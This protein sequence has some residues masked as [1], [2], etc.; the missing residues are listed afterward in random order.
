MRGG[1]ETLAE[2]VVVITGAGRGLGA[3]LAERF[4]N[5]G[6]A[7]GL[8]CLRSRTGADSLADRL[9]EQGV[10]AEVFQADLSKDTEARELAEWAEQHFGR[11]DVLVNNAGTYEGVKLD[12]LSEEAWHRDFDSTAAA[13]FFT[14]RAFLP[15]MR[16]RRAGR[17]INIGDGSCDRPGA[18][19]LAVSYHLGKTGVW[20]L[21][22]SF[23]RSEAAHGIAVNLVSPGLL[24]SSVGLD[25]PLA[26]G[27]P[28]GRYGTSDDVFEAVRFLAE[29]SSNYLTGSNLTV[30]GGW[31]L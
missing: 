19:D 25:N 8:H 29:T 9:R 7:V 28:A 26:D 16:K 21:T 13:A 18:R 12:E 23:A 5:A 31:N 10:R 4:G 20:I 22:R 11:V 17:I 6:Y 2:R 3:A 1:S 15:A 14:T 27:V 24:E 30:G